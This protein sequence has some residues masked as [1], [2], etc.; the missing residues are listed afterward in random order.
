MVLPRWAYND[1]QLLFDFHL[2]LWYLIVF[3]NLQ[4]QGSVD[5]LEIAVHMPGI[6]MIR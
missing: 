3:H 5:M 6:E 2:N 1:V 4:T